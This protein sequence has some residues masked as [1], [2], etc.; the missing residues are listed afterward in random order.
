MRTGGFPCRRV[1]C[2][3]TFPVTDQKSMSS[4][5]VASAERT[6][7]EIAEHDYHHVRLADERP[8][9]PTMQQKRKPTRGI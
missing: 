6:A 5:Q 9:N 2:L 8:F 7:H 4:L 1:G 3:R